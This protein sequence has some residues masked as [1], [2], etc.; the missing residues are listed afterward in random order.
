MQQ[1]KLDRELRE[2]KLREKL[3]LIDTEIK[4]RVERNPPASL[5]TEF[6]GGQVR[7]NYKEKEDGKW[8]DKEHSFSLLFRKIQ[9]GEDEP[10]FLVKIRN[11]YFMRSDLLSLYFAFQEKISKSFKEF[12]KQT[13]SEEE[14]EE[15]KE[16]LKIF[17]EDFR[18]SYIKKFNIMLSI[19]LS[20]KNKCIDFNFPLAV[21]YK[22][23]GLELNAN[24]S[25]KAT[26]I[27]YIYTHFEKTFNDF[28][29][30]C[31]NKQKNKACLYQAYLN[32][33]NSKHIKTY[34]KHIQ[35]TRRV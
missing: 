2:L 26:D 15:L 5:K 7:Y 25:L 16:Q 33:L 24:D 35:N 23:Y 22:Y 19:F 29:K 8:Q 17:E 32:F 18:E 11:E 14:R 1:T 4:E 31:I 30:M 9:V 3:D 6:F 20:Y 10:I 28:F 21:G 13:P 27:L 34:S 12:I